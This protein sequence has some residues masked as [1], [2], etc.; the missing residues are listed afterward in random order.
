M[1]EMT[2][3]MIEEMTEVEIEIISE[4]AEVILQNQVALMPKRE[5]LVNLDLDLDH[6]P[7]LIIKVE[8]PLKTI[9]KTKIKKVKIAIKNDEI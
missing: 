1:I 3:E 7:N 6:C 8:V 2:E 5:C 9:I 4:E